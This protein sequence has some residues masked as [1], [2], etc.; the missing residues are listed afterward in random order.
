[1]RQ[2]INAEDNTVMRI[3]LGVK[4]LGVSDSSS[5]EYCPNKFSKR[6]RRR[7]VVNYRTRYWIVIDHG[8]KTAK[9]GWIFLTLHLTRYHSNLVHYVQLVLTLLCVTCIVR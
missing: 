7:Y 2:T 4:S 1:M 5:P 9:V 3:T 6:R 8:L